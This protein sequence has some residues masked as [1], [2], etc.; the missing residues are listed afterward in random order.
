MR[1]QVTCCALFAAMDNKELG[2]GTHCCP[3]G[4]DRMPALGISL[5][6]IPKTTHV[7]W[8]GC[9]G[10]DLPFEPMT[11][12]P[13]DA[14]PPS[15]ASSSASSAFVFPPAPATGAGGGGGG[16]AA[17]NLGDTRP[18]SFAYST[19]SKAGT[20]NSESARGPARPGHPIDGRLQSSAALEDLTV[21][22]A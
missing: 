15:N 2:P 20:V 17:P 18:G 10:R 7:W 11:P 14:V 3:L 1:H 16:G 5:E 21:G 8:C 13:A 4:P 6:R 9:L 19:V 12:L 22:P